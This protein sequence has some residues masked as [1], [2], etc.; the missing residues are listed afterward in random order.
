[1]PGFYRQHGD[2]IDVFVRLTPKSSVDR[3]EKVVTSADGRAYLVA[4][5]RA[6]PEKGE[7]N[8]ALARLLADAAGLP[9]STVEIVAGHTSRLKTVRISTAAPSALKALDMLSVRG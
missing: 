1:V 2:G 6:V 7:A 9:R 8:A 3:I 5:V 4:R